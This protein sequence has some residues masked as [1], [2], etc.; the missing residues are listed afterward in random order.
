MQLPL[1][2]EPKACTAHANHAREHCLHHCDVFLH[3][4]SVN[5]KVLQYASV[6]GAAKHAAIGVDGHHIMTLWLCAG[7][8]STCRSRWR[9]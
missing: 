3:L 8:S 7:L 1:G 9:S 4:R 5:V 2:A 6:Q